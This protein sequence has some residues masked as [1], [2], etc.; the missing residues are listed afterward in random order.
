MTR[1]ASTGIVIAQTGAMTLVAISIGLPLGLAA[2]RQ[3]WSPI[4][5]GVPVVV[6][7]VRPWGWIAAALASVL[8]GGVA[9]T[10]VPAARVLRLRPAHILRRE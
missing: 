10:V 6:V 5:E 2:G 8:I 9:L 3:I 1:R 7:A 4:A